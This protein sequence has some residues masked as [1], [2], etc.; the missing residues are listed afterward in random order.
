MKA[1]WHACNG[2][3]GP[4]YKLDDALANFEISLIKSCEE[5]SPFCV[6]H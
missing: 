1:D 4:A 6:G 5:L 2:F 3:G